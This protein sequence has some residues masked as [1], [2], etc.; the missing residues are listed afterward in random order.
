MEKFCVCLR[1]LAASETEHSLATFC[2]TVAKVDFL[3]V[4]RPLDKPRLAFIDFESI[5][6]AN[7][8]IE[9]CNN[10]TLSGRKVTA[11]LSYVIFPLLNRMNSIFLPVF[12]NVCFIP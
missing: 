3:S 10:A 5:S 12:N 8:F 7:K 6:L 9:C 2:K 1:N 11:E 4:R